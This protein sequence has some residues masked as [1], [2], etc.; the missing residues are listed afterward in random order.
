MVVKRSCYSNLCVSL[1]LEKLIIYD[2]C[3]RLNDKGTVHYHTAVVRK[4]LAQR[5]SERRVSEN[6]DITI[7][8]NCQVIGKRNG[9]LQQHCGYPLYVFSLGKQGADIRFRFHLPFK[10]HQFQ[11]YTGQVGF[12]IALANIKTQVTFLCSGHIGSVI[13]EAP[14]AIYSDIPVVFQR[15]ISCNGNTATDD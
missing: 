3:T 15:A 2:S 13:V 8:R 11:V 1:R 10:I 4:R 12:Q 9:R 14:A 5:D 6:Y 7:F